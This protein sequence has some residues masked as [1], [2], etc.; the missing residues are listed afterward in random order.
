M[1]RTIDDLGILVIVVGA[2]QMLFSGRLAYLIM[3]KI[4]KLAREIKEGK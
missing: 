2:L 4:D 1:S 3:R